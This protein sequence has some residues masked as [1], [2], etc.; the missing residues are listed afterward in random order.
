MAYCKYIMAPGT[1][2][3]CER[4]LQPIKRQHNAYRAEHMISPMALGGIS[5]AIAAIND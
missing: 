2:S 4:L 3:H 5:T 1:S